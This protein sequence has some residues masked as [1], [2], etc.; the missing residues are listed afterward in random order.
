VGGDVDHH[1]SLYPWAVLIVCLLVNFS[2]GFKHVWSVFVPYIEG[3]FNTSR[4][5]AVLPFSLMSITNI[6]GFLFID[7]IR[8]RMGLKKLMVLIT[9]ST[10]AGLLLT[11]L[12]QNMTLLTVSYAFIFGLGHSLGY[13]LAVTL[14]VRWFYGSRRGLAAGLTAGGY[15]LGTLVLAP[16]TSYL[17]KYC[18]GWRGT[19]FAFSLMNFIIMLLATL[20]LREP[21]HEVQGGSGKGVDGLGGYRPTE[22]L[23]LKEF[24]LAWFMIFT[25][26][27]FDGFAAT[28]LVPF[29]IGYAHLE[30]VSASIAVSV[31][32]A[33]NF[34]SRVIMGFL[35]E[36]LGIFKILIISY[37]ISS[38]NALLFPTYTNL[39][40]ISVGS[41]II[42][43][44]HGTNVALIPL[45]TSYLWGAK[46]LG[47]NSG[48]LLTAATSAMLVGPLIG[49]LSYDITGSYLLSF[50]IIFIAIVI[51]DV[52]LYILYRW[53]RNR[54]E[55]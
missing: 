37:A 12:S 16:V 30:E 35:T 31:Y 42:G 7:Y 5:T 49:S 32:S 13:M 25:T 27:L 52:L 36:Y 18:L 46:Y 44:L 39:L 6:I 34:L 24:Y 47:S 22:V 3:E 9:S 17:I 19:V 45:I 55:I 29:A 38:A 41:S 15:S 28:H 10:T 4:S 2:L 53:S 48:L 50:N 11:A 51:G 54:S 14:G 40:L 23:R 1:S 33:T 21:P 8:V 43:L 20:I 26:S